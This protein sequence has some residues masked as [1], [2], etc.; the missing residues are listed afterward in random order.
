MDI[1]ERQT[2]NS[3]PIDRNLYED[4]L[5]VLRKTG[6]TLWHFSEKE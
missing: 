4:D 6:T 3:V 1:V 2:R 5:E